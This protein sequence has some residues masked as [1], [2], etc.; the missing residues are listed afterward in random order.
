MEPIYFVG[1]SKGGVGK[2]MVAMAL[3]DYLLESGGKPLLIETDTS[4]PDVAKA[5][6]REVPA[7]S[8]N[9]DTG[10]GWV[11]FLNS[12][13]AHEGAVVVNGA[14]RN[15]TGVGT[16]G[17]NL[18]SSLIDLKRSLVTLWVVNTQR[19]GLELLREYLDS[20][21]QSKQ[22]TVHIIRNTFFGRPEQF[23]M[24]EGSKLKA[25]VEEAGGLVL[26]FPELA[27]RITAEINNKRLSIAEASKAA[28]IG[29]RAEINRWRSLVKAVFAQV[30]K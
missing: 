22:H 14:A 15:N 21:P 11:D 24:L 13:D 25:S 6:G 29:N 30:A 17:G 19:D 8:I 10:D 27:S 7:Q 20:L 18:G 4:N 26:D 1:G 9:L 12:V 2:S 23:E 16:Y 5:Y 28:P 3:L